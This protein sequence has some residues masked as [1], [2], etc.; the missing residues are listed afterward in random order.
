MGHEN[1]NCKDNCNCSSCFEGVVLPVGPKGDQGV[2]G[3]K[4]DT[5][6]TGATGA[7]GNG[8]E[9]VEFTSN[10]GGQPQYTQGTIDTYT[11]TFTNGG[12]TTFGVY[13]GADGAQ[14]V[15]GNQGDTGLTGNDGP[16]GAPGPAGI[17]GNPGEDGTVTFFGDGVPSNGLGK[18]GD[19]YNDTTTSFPQM[20]VYQKDADSWLLKGTFGNVVNPGGGPAEDSYLFRA[21][22]VVDSNYTTTAEV[23]LAVE[24]DSTVPNF[25]NGGVWNGVNFVSDQDLTDTDF[26]VENMILDNNTASPVTVDINLYRNTGGVENLEFTSSTVM[27]ASETG[28]SVTFSRTVATLLTN[29]KVYLKASLSVVGDVTIKDGVFYNVDV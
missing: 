20:D 6:A 7:T 28:T 4:G 23:F 18:S 10:S 25:D 26:V 16:Q 2:P 13:N 8:I 27:A 19:V 11:I 12:T 24:D 14:G 9:S 22:K 3:A 15:Q 1:C 21:T 29:D 5:G 17:Q